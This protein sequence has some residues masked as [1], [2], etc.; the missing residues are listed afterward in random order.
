MR[1]TFAD[2]VLDTQLHTLSRGG[3]YLR[4]RPKVF[5]VLTYLLAHRDCV[6]SK[7]ELCDQVWA[8]QAVSD[9]VIENCIK[10][11]RR[12]IGDDGRAQRLIETQYGYGYRFGA[13][14]TM[15]PETHSGTARDDAPLAE[16]KIVTVLCCASTM[17]PMRTRQSPEVSY[18]RLLAMEDIVRCEVDRYGGTLQP[19]TGDHMVAIFGA[20]MA[21]EDHAQ[22]AMLAALGIRQQLREQWHTLAAVGA[23]PLMVSMGIHTGRAA[24]GEIEKS[25]E[26]GP[27][28]VGNTVAQAVALQERATSGSIVCSEVTARLLRQVVRLVAVQPLP[29]TDQAAS[30]HAYQLLGRTVRRVPALLAV[31]PF[32]GRTRE[33]AALHAVWTQVETGQGHVVG[34]VGEPGMGKSRLVH[35]FRRILRGRPYTYVRGRCVSYGQATPYQLLLTLLQH[36]CRITHADRPT[37]IAAKM[38]RRLRELEMEPAAAPY[39]LHLLGSETEPEWLAGV[40]PE[41]RKART[42]AIL[43]QMSLNG[44]RYHPL[45]LEVE[46]AQT[47]RE[48][49]TVQPTLTLPDTVHA[50]LTARIDRLPPLAKRVLQTASVIG[51]EVPCSLLEAITNLPRADLGQSLAQL[52]AAEL[53]HETHL[54]PA[55]IYT[56]KHVLTQ[57]AAYHSLLP[58]TRQQ[59]HQQIAHVLA[60][61]FPETAVRKPELLAHH[62]T[63]AGLSETAL[64]Y[65][66]W[67]GQR[68]VARSAHVEAIMH[69]RK[70]LELLQTLPVT[71]ERDRQ[72]LT[73]QRNLAV[74]LSLRHDATLEVEHA[75]A[76]AVAL[77]RQV[78]NT[79]ELFPVLYGLRRFYK[80]RGKLQKAR[81][82]GEQLLTLAQGQHDPVLLLY[83]HCALGDTL[84]WLG[85]FQ[86][87]R[88]Q[89]EQGMTYYDP[90]L[91]SSALF[92]DGS[93]SPGLVCLGSLSWTL[94]YLGYPEQAL[95]RSNV[96][97]MLAYELGHPLSLGIAL[98]FAAALHMFRQEWQALRERAEALWGLAT[99][100]GFAH[101]LASATRYLGIALFRQGQI[102][103]GIAQLQQGIAALQ[104]M[105]TQ[106]GRVSHLA[107]LAQ[108][109]GHA[110]QV[111]EGLR[112]LD[113]A[114]AATRD[115]EERSAHAHWYRIKGELLL[116][117]PRP[118]THQA[119]S[120]L[121]QALAIARQQQAKSLELQAALPLCR[122]WQQQGRREKARQLLAP[123]YGWFTEGFETADLQEAK[124]LLE[125]LG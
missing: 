58:S 92:F 71:P 52:Q 44:S 87:A 115:M 69:F 113:K 31:T 101:L 46:L 100:H 5:Q 121:Q 24:V 34:I 51:R 125:E 60:E 88:V 17:I 96:A 80:R 116:L 29:A 8:A 21:Q 42:F 32:V 23:E 39:L 102:T 105:R 26:P 9:A 106:E 65:W 10:A 82:L 124:A 119:D 59:L 63:E 112:L 48:R 56:F 2:C 83:G 93:A 3:R 74:P 38:H 4:L 118:D 79:Q 1:Y 70:G 43:L 108:T 35:E 55:S 104:T 117:P 109:Y 7:Q 40:S 25:S 37:A 98:T 47:I 14:V 54:V 91:S 62:Y 81:E 95:Q 36:A 114:M 53:L 86:A 61:R 57:E 78:G 85:E 18:Q 110:G 66:Q 6:V 111:V 30:V 94:W 75:Y 72:E 76:R 19:T 20:P 12:A 89:L 99:Q 49:G 90:Q 15:S 97:L 41:E 13:S 27:A 123:I 16:Q 122:L 77:C 84:L 68:A 28:L 107:W 50:V 22:R 67:A 45:L 33:L 11:V 120:C 73:L 103:E 64:A